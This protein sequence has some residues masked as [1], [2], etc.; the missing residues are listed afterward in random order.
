MLLRPTYIVNRSSPASKVLTLTPLS[1]CAP[2]LIFFVSSF[3]GVCPETFCHLANS[4]SDPSVS[5]PYRNPNPRLRTAVPKTLTLFP[6]LPF[7][8]NRESVFNLQQ[9]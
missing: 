2:V 1:M 3:R 4:L 5:A 9:Q 7:L 6:V 8:G